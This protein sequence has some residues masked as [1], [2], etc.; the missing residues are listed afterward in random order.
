MPDRKKRSRYQS[1]QGVYLDM[2]KYRRY[3]EKF[4]VI[5]KRVYVRN[6]KYKDLS[7]DA[8]SKLDKT[9]TIEQLMKVVVA[10]EWIPATPEQVAQYRQMKEK[11]DLA[12]TKAVLSGQRTHLKRAETRLRKAQAEVRSTTKG[13]AR[14]TASIAKLEEKLA[15]ERV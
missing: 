14:L 2:S 1:Y 12:L 10:K 8:L 15:S 11:S 4:K 9:L 6:A 3:T 5:G 13:I 7:L